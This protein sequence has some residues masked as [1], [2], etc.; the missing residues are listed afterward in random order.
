VS[1]SPITATD[2]L[3]E[4]SLSHY[5]VTS[6]YIRF[7]QALEWYPWKRA[8]LYELI[9]EGLVKSF[10][11]MEPGASRGLRLV[12]RFSM[13]EFLQ[14]A[15]EQAQR[16][17]ERMSHSDPLAAIMTLGEASDAPYAR[18]LGEFRQSGST[19]T[20][21][22]RLGDVAIYKQTKGKQP[23]TFEVVTIRRREASVAFGMEFPAAE[24][25]P[26]NE[27]WG[28][29]GF[30]YRTPEEAERKFEELTDKRG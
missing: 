11:L 6:R 7:A 26:H 9:R 17:G 10:V 21:L 12:A 18:L 27:D 5:T 2:G 13:D 8:K 25:Y 4:I 19:L 22:K 16:G 24:Y 30:T 28:I 1:V 14:K 15:A 29:H 3:A 23:P 20:Q